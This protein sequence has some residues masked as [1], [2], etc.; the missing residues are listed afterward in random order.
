MSTQI[1]IAV[2]EQDDRFLI[3]QRPAGVALAGLWEFPGG[4]VEAGETPEA[5]AVRECLEET[6][7]EVQVIGQYPEHLQQ[8]NH[9]R[10][11]LHFFRCIPCQA[12]ATPLAPYRWVER[13][14]LA[15][16]EFPAGNRG[17]LDALLGR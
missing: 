6:G 1:A 2:V 14:E 10:V 5:A 16:Y 11:H 12:N 4:K 9:D 8:Y 15:K 17:L 13:A 3:G 7:L